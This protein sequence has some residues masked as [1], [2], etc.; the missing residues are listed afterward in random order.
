MQFPIVTIATLALLISLGAPARLE[1]RDFSDLD[2]GVQTVRQIKWPRRNIEVAFSTSLVNPGPNVKPGSDVV[3]AARRALARWSTMANVNFVVSWSSATSVSPASGGDRISLITVADTPENEAFNADSTTGRTRVFFDPESGTIAEADVCINPQPKSDDGVELQFSTDG[4]PGTFDLEATFTHEIGHLLGLDHS[5]VLAAT[6][7]SHQA[8][9][10]TYGLPALTERTL[11]EDDRQRIRSLYGPVGAKQHLGRIEGRLINS[12]LPGTNDPLT[13]A[14]VWAENIVSGRLVAS[15]VTLADGTYQLDGLTPGQY[16]VLAAPRDEES[17]S[18]GETSSAKRRFRSFEVSSSTV[19]KADVPTTLNYNLVAPQLS[20]AALHPRLVGLGPELSTV[21]LPLEPGKRVK[22]FL[23][24][25]GLDQVTPASVSVNSPFFAVDPATLTREQ[26]ASPY[27]VISFEL[28][29]AVN[30]PFGDYTIRLQSNSG[31]TAYVPGAI[32]IDP[33]VASSLANPVDDSKF[34]VLQHYKDF[35]GREPDQAAIE[36]ALA[37]FS[38]CGTRSECLRTR[39]IDVSASLF[40]QNE[41]PATGNL[42]YGLYS[43][44]FGRRPRFSEFE[45]DRALLVGHGTDNEKNRRAFLLSFVQR[46]DFERKFP[47]E[48]KGQEFVEALL[49]SLSQSSAADL[50]PDKTTLTALYDGTNNGRAAILARIVGNASLTD[51][52]YNSSF[53]LMQYFNYLRR[54]PDENGFDSWVNVLKGKPS[55]DP[56]AAR[57]VICSF[58]NSNEYQSRFGMLAT[59]STSE[60]GN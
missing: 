51:T 57:S 8:F 47:A 28:N 35:V 53:V 54:D 7:Q 39:R 44:A 24:G 52:Q 43:V 33:G 9:N 32:T 59:H 29:V 50:S 41:L 42:L 36:N 12:L 55:R 38:Q 25:D 46:A 3:G 45:S 14:N 34:F 40:F 5:A 58:L 1:T 16:R 6:M 31:E 21:A 48:M 30:A 17:S 60:C 49:A 22:V 11:S 20:P 19:V 4:T 2:P 37:Q 15:D 18:E 56:E 27:P 10:G 23:S 26:F 13:G